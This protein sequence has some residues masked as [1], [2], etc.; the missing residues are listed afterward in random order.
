MTHT[1]QRRGLDPSCPGKEL[2]ILAMIPRKHI[3]KKGIKGAMSALGSRIL[4][5]NPNCWIFQDITQI[6]IPQFGI[7]QIL[8]EWLYKLVPKW[9]T[10]LVMWFTCHNSS[11]ITAAYTDVETV[12]HLL[13]DLKGTWLAKNQKKGYPV[14]ICLSG[15]DEDVHACCQEAGLQEHTY[16]HSLGIFGAVRDLP[17]EDELA[18]ITMCGHGLIASSRIRYLVERIRNREL[19]PKE[20][21]EDIAKPCI[22]GVVN[23]ERAE[24]TFRRLAMV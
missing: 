12:K 3:R 20:A 18:L 19:T 23:K 24:E 22:C 5:H 7:G 9:I 6:T 13:K 16:L 4:R 8:I 2:I 11:V 1:S 17:S 10:R 15:L 14:S 21:A